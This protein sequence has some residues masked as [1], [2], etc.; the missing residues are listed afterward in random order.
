MI[1]A[2]WSPASPRKDVTEMRTILDS[3]R[4]EP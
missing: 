2:N 1:E 3:I 4:I